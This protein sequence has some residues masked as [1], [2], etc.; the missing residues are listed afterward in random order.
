MVRNPKHHEERERNH[1][2]VGAA[3]IVIRPKIRDV[4]SEAQPRPRTDPDP[5]AHTADRRVIEFRR[6]G[7]HA[8]IT[9]GG[10]ICVRSTEVDVDES[11][12]AGSATRQ[13]RNTENR[14][15]DRGSNASVHIAPPSNLD[16]HGAGRP[17]AVTLL[18]SPDSRNARWP[19]SSARRSSC[20]PHK[21][22]GIPR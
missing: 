7:C 15:I 19:A 5:T 17:G 10:V 18:R 12:G 1:V 13:N 2:D 11:L 14:R 9:S 21:R 3:S 22:C 6:R 16:A 20:R 8:R 4:A